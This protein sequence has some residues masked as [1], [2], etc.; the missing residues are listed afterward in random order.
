M[1]ATGIGLP[2][3]TVEFAQI[4]FDNGVTWSVIAGRQR[5][6]GVKSIH[7]MP[8]V[9]CPV[10][11]TEQIINDIALAKLLKEHITQVGVINL[12]HLISRLLALG[13]VITNTIAEMAPCAN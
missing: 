4:A 5:L 9:N 11:N 3:D 8:D 6:S 7:T 10:V 1:F 13:G 2:S 12:P